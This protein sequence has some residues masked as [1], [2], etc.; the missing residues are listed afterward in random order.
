[1]NTLATTNSPYNLLVFDWDGTLVDSI[2]RIVTSL[3]N[4]SQ[5]VT[6]ASVTEAAARDVIGL[7]L[8]EAIQRL[9]PEM[10]AEQVHHVAEAYKQHYLHENPVPAN[11]FEGVKEFLDELIHQGFTLAIATGKSRT[12]LDHSL[13]E[14]QLASRFTTTR[15]AGEYRSKPHPEMLLGILQDLGTTAEQALMIGDS[16][17]DLMMARN[18]GVA[19]IAVT[20]GVQQAEVLLSHQPLACF[21]RITDLLPFLSH[22]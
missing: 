20:H 19:S 13:Q 10:N 9:H 14:H 17:H 4:A 12:G 18:A 21:D 8:T 2:E 3:Q 15:C 1:M 16:E 5:K 22:N 6:G 7:G 11:L